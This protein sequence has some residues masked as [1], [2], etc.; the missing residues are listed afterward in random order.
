MAINKIN[1]ASKI[2][3]GQML[4]IP[5]SSTA[6]A[7]KKSPKKSNSSGGKKAKTTAVAK[8]TTHKIKPGETL[9]GIAL[10]YDVTTKSLMQANNISNASKVRS[11]QVLTI[12]KAGG[13]AVASKSSKAKKTHTVK[14]GDTYWAIARKYDLSTSELLKLNKKT[15]S[16][17]LKPGDTLLVSL[18]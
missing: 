5:A 15:K 9:L 11:G 1:D 12:P 18:Q 14:S 2:R 8:A 6:V 16:S 7:A 10:K 17:T 13:K 4:K 3:S